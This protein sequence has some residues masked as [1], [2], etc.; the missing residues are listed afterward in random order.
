VRKIRAGALAL[1]FTLVLGV[2]QAGTASAAKETQVTGDGTVVLRGKTY[3]FN[4]A[5]ATGGKGGFTVFDLADR[6]NRVTAGKTTCF[7][8]IDANTIAIVS[9]PSKKTDPM[10]QDPY[11]VI[12]AYDSPYSAPDRIYIADTTSSACPPA[13]PDPLTLTP[14][15]TGNITVSP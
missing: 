13:I 4:I 1:L 5:G 10:F 15:T 6:K 14:I 3:N 12:I 8:Q 9:A 7:F 11:L 2:S